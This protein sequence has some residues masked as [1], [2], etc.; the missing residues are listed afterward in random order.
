MSKEESTRVE[1][2]TPKAYEH[3]TKAFF[4]IYISHCSCCCLL[5]H[6][7]TV[8]KRII[9]DSQKFFLSRIVNI[10]RITFASWLPVWTPNAHLIEAHLILSDMNH[11]DGRT[12]EHT[13]IH[14]LTSGVILQWAV[15]TV[16]TIL[17]F[18]IFNSRIWR[19]GGISVVNCVAVGF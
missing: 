18:V 1:M 17:G 2:C 3:S 19:K 9:Q 14:S 4:V 15:R 16:R 8:T 12:D 11:S 10:H 6:K 5:S 13:S 7:H